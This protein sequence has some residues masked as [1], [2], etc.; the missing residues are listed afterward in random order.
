MVT[1]YYDLERKTIY[2]A[3][4]AGVGRLAVVHGDV[5]AGEIDLVVLPVISEMGSDGEYSTCHHFSISV[6]NWVH[7]RIVLSILGEGEFISLVKIRVEL[8]RGAS[9]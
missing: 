8:K 7:W 3:A 1:L 2:L 4:D 5:A 6:S 9:A